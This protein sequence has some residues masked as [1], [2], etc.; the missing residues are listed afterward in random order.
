MH[1]HHIVFRSQGGLDYSLNLVPLTYEQH[2][3]P[4]GP[5]H[6]KLIDRI[7]KLDLQNKLFEIFN[8]DGYT[9]DQIAQK[10]GKST[11]YFER[12][13]KAVPNQAGIYKPEDIVRKLMGGKLYIKE[14]K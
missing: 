1:K 9:I 7:L 4:G 12:H 6:N 14:G 5:H 2:E 8:D 10:L 3:G 13:F 11:R